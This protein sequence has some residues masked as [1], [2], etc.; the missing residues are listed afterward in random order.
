[1][2]TAATIASMVM[3]SDPRLKINIEEIGQAGNLK[4]HQ[5][6]WKPET[7]GTLVEGCSNMG[8][9]ADEVKEKYPHHIYEFG[10]FMVVDYPAL[11]D[12]L[13]E[14]SVMEAA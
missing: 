4:I 5:W 9:M 11:L 6:D 14:L 10:G 1:M 8:F 3:F 13:E 12:E 7:K 2:K